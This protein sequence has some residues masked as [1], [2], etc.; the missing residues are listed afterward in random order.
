LTNLACPTPLVIPFETVDW[1]AIP[2]TTHPGETGVAEWRT[3]Q[4]PGLR[5]RMVTYSPNYLADHW[6]EKGHIIYCIDG[7]IDSELK[8]GRTFKL[9][10]GMSYHV[11]D[12]ASSH[13]STTTAGA[14][15]FIVDGDFLAGKV[16]GYQA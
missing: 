7:E 11:T 6:C 3:I 14:R 4:F 1:S 10:Q 9:S 2:V 12:H 16:P 15:L 13:R 8:D 5:I